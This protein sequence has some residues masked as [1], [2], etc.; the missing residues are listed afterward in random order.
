VDYHIMRT[1]LRT[2]SVT[3]VDADVSSSLVAREWV[4]AAVEAGL[5]RAA[6]D[7]IRSL[8][9]LSGLDIASVDG[10]LFRLGRTVCLETEPPKCEECPL[11]ATC[12]RETELFQPIFRTTAY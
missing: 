8:C 11:A 5:R 7:A 9:A 2:G 10:F 4:G 3:I 6:R 1:A 12:A